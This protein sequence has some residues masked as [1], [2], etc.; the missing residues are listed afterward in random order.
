[1]PLHAVSGEAGKQSHRKINS[2]QKGER[3]NRD[4]AHAFRDFLDQYSLY[5]PLPPSLRKHMHTM[6]I[7][8]LR[9]I[10]KK[11]GAYGVIPY[12]ATGIYFSMKNLGYPIRMKQSCLAA[13]VL[14]GAAFCV[15]SGGLLYMLLRVQ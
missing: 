10:L 13:A 11:E 2:S 8:Q 3:M 4:N 7:R 9:V 6:K 15:I 5:Q 14:T 1:M 12:M